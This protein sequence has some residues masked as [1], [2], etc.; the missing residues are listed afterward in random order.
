MLDTIG[1][2][3][4]ADEVEDFLGDED[5]GKR[6]KLIDRLLDR[7]EYVDYWTLKWGDILRVNSDKLGAQGMLAFNLWLRDAFRSNMP[8]NQMVAELVT[9]QGS[10][11]SNGPANFLPG[12]QQSRRPGR[13]DCPGL[14]GRP[15]P[16]RQVPPS[17]VRS[18]RAG[19]LLWPGGVL[20]AGTD[21]AKRRVRS[22]RRRTGHLRRQVGR[23]LSAADRQE[24]GTAAIG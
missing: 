6:T 5:P 14:H 13:D 3:P 20:R 21:Q 10:I 24:D 4:R 12:R 18:L 9:A 15:A 19:R 8:V 11:F 16:V 1:T 2:T 22:F 23:G 17:P 7:P